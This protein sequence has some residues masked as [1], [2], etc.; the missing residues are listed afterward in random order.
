M[1]YSESKQKSFGPIKTILWA[2]LVAG[3][4]DATAGVIVYFIFKALNPIQVLQYIASG[5]YGNEAFEGGLLMAL[6]GMILHFVIAYA[7]T[8]GFFIVYPFASSV[9]AKNI[10]VTG[11]LYG[12]FIWLFMNL[13][14]LPNS[15]TPKSPFGLVSMIEIIWHVFLVGLPLVL[16]IHQYYTRRI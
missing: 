16:I 10:W 7:F 11:L 15:L 1:K 12:L 2:G 4:L 8:V 5:I 14:V 3:I 13:L 9:F 6:I